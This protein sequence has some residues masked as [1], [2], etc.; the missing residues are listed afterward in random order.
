MQLNRERISRDKTMYFKGFR[1]VV[2]FFALGNGKVQKSKFHDTQFMDN[3]SAKINSNQS[4]EL[5][6]Y[7]SIPIPQLRSFLMEN[8]EFNL[9]VN[10]FTKKQIG[11]KADSKDQLQL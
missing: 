6:Q 10:S 9:A 8:F 5:L 3:F 1:Y 4:N 11:K 7:I 2:Q